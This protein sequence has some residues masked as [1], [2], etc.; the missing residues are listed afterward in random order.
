MID[1]HSHILPGVDDGPPT[2]EGSLA[3]AAAAVEDGITAIAAT[4]HVRDD[5]PT[6]AETMER[7]VHELRGALAEA[8]LPLRLH[9]GAEIALDRLWSLADD[10]LA[11]FGLAGTPAYVLLEFPYV[12]WAPAL[13]STVLA[14]RSRGITPV[15]AHPERNAE[16]QHDPER[17]RP[18]VLSGALVQVTA[19]SVDGRL[20]RRARRTA[21]ELVDRDLAHVI[22]S[23]AH[24][25]DV[26]AIG[27]RDAAAAIGDEALAEWLTLRV[28]E[29]IVAGEA[30]PPRPS[31]G[32]ERP[33]RRRFLRSV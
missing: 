12:G 5:Y 10:E 9:P 17:L 27:M 23:D 32:R 6:S 8:G 29:A 11:R 1:L 13:P 31:S 19:A 4:P 24:M 22:A 14:L 28:P 20:G 2:L 18:V 25:P 16:V 15:V 30:P 7:K 33:A 21:F 3:M 26:R